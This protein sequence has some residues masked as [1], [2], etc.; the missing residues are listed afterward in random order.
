MGKK[1]KQSIEQCPTY[2][3]H[4]LCAKNWIKEIKLFFFYK[5]ANMTRYKHTNILSICQSLAAHLWFADYGNFKGHRQRMLKRPICRSSKEPSNPPLHLHCWKASKRN[6][7]RLFWASF[8]NK[9]LH[10]W[11]RTEPLS[12]FKRAEA[13]IPT[14]YWP[15]VSIESHRQKNCTFPWLRAVLSIK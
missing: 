3:F 15:S 9:L 2:I 11:S 14:T 13:P 8:Q 12:V 1:A 5:T 6:L 10:I 4:G 7:P